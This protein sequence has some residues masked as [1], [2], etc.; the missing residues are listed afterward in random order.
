MPAKTKS[1]A[2]SGRSR[3]PA[4][5]KQVLVIM[6]AELARQIKIA[7]AEDERKMSHLVEDAVRDW[8]DRRKGK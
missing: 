6:D 7:A 4:G 2:A 3:A 1:T 5:K 8:L